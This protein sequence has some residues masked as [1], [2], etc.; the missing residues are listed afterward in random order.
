LRIDSNFSSSEIRKTI[1]TKWQ[2]YL[3]KYGNLFTS[4]SLNGSSPPSVFVGSYGYP[5][6]GIG[7]MVPPVHGDTT[8]LDSPELWL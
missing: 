2:E 6:V 3:S 5:K 8:L 4:D 7:P 1:E